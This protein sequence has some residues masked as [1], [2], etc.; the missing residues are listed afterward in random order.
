MVSTQTRSATF[1]DL[2]GATAAAVS[3]WLVPVFSRLDARTQV[4]TSTMALGASLYGV[5]QSGRLSDSL[6]ARRVMR[7]LGLELASDMADLEYDR[8]LLLLKERYG[9]V[10]VAQVEPEVLLPAEEVWEPV[11]PFEFGGAFPVEDLASTLATATNSGTLII[12]PSGCGKTRLMQHAI[13]KAHAHYEGMVDF[14]IID[15]KGEEDGWLGIENSSNDYQLLDDDMAEDGLNQLMLMKGQLKRVDTKI[16]MIAVIDEWNN[17]VSSLENSPELKREDVK[18]AISAGRQIVTKGRSK[19]LFGWMTTH[20]P[21]TKTIGMDSA[22]RQSFNIVILARGNKLGLISSVLKN[23]YT[24]VDD[25]ATREKLLIAYQH[26]MS[27]GDASLKEKPVALTNLCGDWRLV[28]LP[29]YRDAPEPIERTVLNGGSAEPK[30]KQA[31]P[32]KSDAPDSPEALFAEMAEQLQGDSPDAELLSLFQEL[33]GQRP[34]GNVTERNNLARFI[35][36]GVQ[37]VQQSR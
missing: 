20:T 35:R 7:E 2:A 10:E 29:D 6:K 1:W 28:R 19:R 24:F 31:Q 32:T 21:D 27:N 22:T 30:P 16:P 12:A 33:T 37:K 8:R 9:L 17:G 23:T 4:I 15:C 26:F 18:A 11:N 36:D 3:L 13:S 34:P 14:Q 5:H 25:D